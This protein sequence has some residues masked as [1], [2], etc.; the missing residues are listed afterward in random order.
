VVTATA[1]RDWAPVCFPELLHDVGGSCHNPADEADHSLCLSGRCLDVGRFGLCIDLCAVNPCPS[2]AACVQFS[3]G[4]LAWEPLCLA[5]CGPARPCN[6]DPQLDCEVPDS[7]GELGFTVVDPSEP[8]GHTYCAPR[9]CQSGSDCPS[10][11]CDTQ[12]GGFCR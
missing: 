4:P 11:L 8:P 3:G 7:A 2:Y 10:G 6:A 9:R 5:R 1:E 12:A